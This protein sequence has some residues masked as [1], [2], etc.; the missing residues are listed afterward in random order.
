MLF[1][2]NDWAEDHHD[3]E[4]VDESG[5]RLARKRF[6]DGVGGMAGLHALI[7]DYLPDVA[8]PG[9][10]VIGIETDRGPWVTALIAA[11]YQVFAIN[12]MQASR[13]RERY[14]TS[15][16]K[17]DRG[18]AHVLAEIVRLDRAHHRQVAGDSDLSEA[19]KVLARSHQNL[20]WTRQRQT[21]QLRSMLR[22]YYPAALASF[23]DLAGRDAL[24]VLATAPTPTAGRA[25]TIDAI[26]DLLRQAG[27]QRNLES[28]A[29]KIHAALQAEYLAALPLTAQAFG[30]SVRALVTVIAALTAEITA[31]HDEVDA[32][33]GQHPDA[34]IYLSQP[35]LG[36]ILAAR[37]LAEFGDD[38]DRYVTGKSRKNYAGTS[39]ITRASGTK[40]AVLA[41]YARNRRIGDALFQQAFCA[42]TTSPGAR[43]H[44]DAMRARGIG[45]NDALRRLAN[46]LVGILHGCLRH[47][48]AYDEAT[49]WHPTHQDQQ[50]AA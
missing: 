48:T 27:R 22:E 15:G 5:R 31:L 29:T 7:A 8:E 34:E 3:V 35:G 1:V 17:S 14:S 25:L 11:G 45:H 42:L 28:A 50:T 9:D 4:V 40:T 26:I 10:V 24:A 13:Y 39:P 23:P 16:A 41:R 20:I 33:F 12:P 18:D 47:R 32:Y 36:T 2:G 6:P 21:N 49:A 37:V 30:V 38:T 19:V 44:Y 43:T 46:R